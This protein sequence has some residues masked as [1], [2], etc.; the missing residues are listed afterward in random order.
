VVIGLH[1]GFIAAGM[2]W[3]NASSRE[4]GPAAR[5]GPLASTRDRVP[6]GWIAVVRRFGGP[7]RIRD[8]G[9]SRIYAA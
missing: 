8:A 9:R 7:L 6:G 2:L 5:I 3:A 1:D 4:Q